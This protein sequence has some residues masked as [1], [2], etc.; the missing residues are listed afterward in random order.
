MG[1]PPLKRQ[2][3]ESKLPQKLGSSTRSATA[4]AAAAAAAA[5]GATGLLK[6]DGR[7]NVPSLATATG[8]GTGTGVGLGLGSGRRLRSSPLG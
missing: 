7:E 5:A 1:P 8:T 4:A 6:F 2:A 3:T